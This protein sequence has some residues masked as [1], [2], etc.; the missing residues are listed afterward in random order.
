[1]WPLLLWLNSQEFSYASGGRSF[2]TDG[3]SLTVTVVGGVWMPN[4][5][6]HSVEL[7]GYEGDGALRLDDF[8][9]GSLL[10]TSTIPVPIRVQSIAFDVTDFVRGKTGFVG[11]NLRLDSPLGGQLNYGSLEYDTV[12]LLSIVVSS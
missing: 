11:F 10:S 5:T 2:L 8:G 3:Q 9:A 6:V 7:F 1:M 4:A 12:P